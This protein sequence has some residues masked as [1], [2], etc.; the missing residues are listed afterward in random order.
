[1]CQIK[2]INY[3]S[4]KR[5]NCTFRLACNVSQWSPSE[6]EYSNALSFL[7]TNEMCR[8]S[9]FR[10]QYDAKLA[11]VGRLLMQYIL[12]ERFDKKMLLNRTKANKPCIHEHKPNCK[13]YDQFQEGHDFQFNIS[14][15]GDYAVGVGA[16]CQSLGVD[17]MKYESDRYCTPDELIDAM[18]GQLTEQ[19]YRHIQQ[20]E[21][22]LKCFYRIWT[23]KESYIKAVGDGLQIDLAKLDFVLKENNSENKMVIDTDLYIH[24]KK[25]RSWIFEETLLD[26]DTPVC[27]GIEE[28]KSTPIEE[29]SNRKDG[30][31]FK[32][33]SVDDMIQRLRVLQ[34]NKLG[35][36]NDYANKCTCMSDMHTNLNGDGNI[37]SIKKLGEIL[38]NKPLSANISRIDR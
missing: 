26:S 3:P 24:G 20:S 33:I 37:L 1:M 27:V 21:F 9:R 16:T 19:E 13:L 18:K 34:N 25:Q 35:G 30:I 22:P 31:M 14:H 10:F 17:V 2:L 28:S 29:A 32:S 12:A 6:E 23:L 5:E 4:R 11:I 36:M 7:K 38:F 15:H 8:I